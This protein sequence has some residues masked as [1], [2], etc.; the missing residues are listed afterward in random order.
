[1]ITLKLGA[2]QLVLPDSLIWT[3]EFGWSPVGMSPKTGST[4]ALILHLGKRQAGRPITLD[5]V[6][7]KAWITRD[8]CDRFYAWQAIPDAD[9]DLVVRG[10]SHKVK[11]DNSQGPGFT[12]RAQWRLFDSEHDGRTDYLPTFKFIE[13]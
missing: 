2:T 1:M 5:G 10:L 8:E 3:N 12:A 6:E 9:F 11:F 4:G 13:I 7:S